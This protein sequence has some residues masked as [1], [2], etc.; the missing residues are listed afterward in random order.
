MVLESFGKKFTEMELSKIIGFSPRKGVS[1]KMMD[2]L[3]EIID[4]GYEYRFDSSL[5]EIED[6]TRAGFYPI[7]LVDPS[8]LYD[9]PEEE[10]GHYI[11]IKNINEGKVI[12]NDPDGEH[13]NENREIDKKKFLEAWE[14]RHK[15]VFIIKGERK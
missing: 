4:I 9:I 13:G 12:I 8:I 2:S 10:H 5:E 15:L 6:I 3:C 1:P 14:R 11:I 7:V